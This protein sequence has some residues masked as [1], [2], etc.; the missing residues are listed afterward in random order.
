MKSE[1]RRSELGDGEEPVPAGSSVRL[2]EKGSACW[3]SCGDAGIDSRSHGPGAAQGRRACQRRRQVPPSSLDHPA[4]T[5]Q[6]AGVAR[7]G[8]LVQ[9]GRASGGAVRGASSPLPEPWEMGEFPS[10]GW[11]LLG[12][13]GL[14]VPGSGGRAGSSPPLR[15]GLELPWEC[16]VLWVPGSLQAEQRWLCSGRSW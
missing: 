4:T 14:A 5:V 10:H 13:E 9:E 2:W 15:S 3:Q 7:D 8:E 16:S 1:G 11:C 6:G 12:A